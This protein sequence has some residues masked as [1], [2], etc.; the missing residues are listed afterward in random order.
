VGFTS[1]IPDDEYCSKT[2]QA[3]ECDHECAAARRTAVHRVPGESDQVQ[4]SILH[5]CGDTQDGERVCLPLQVQPRKP[6]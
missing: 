1:T 5:G 2:P 3:D 4:D 6:L